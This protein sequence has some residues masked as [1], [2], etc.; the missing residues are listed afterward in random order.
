MQNKW[1]LGAS[2]YI[3]AN[4]TRKRILTP[5]FAI[6][7]PDCSS[8]WQWPHHLPCPPPTNAENV[9]FCHQLYFCGWKWLSALSKVSP[10]LSHASWKRLR[11]EAPDVGSQTSFTRSFVNNFGS[12]G[13]NKLRCFKRICLETP[14][15]LAVRLNRS[16]LLHHS[17]VCADKWGQR[18]WE[19]V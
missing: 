11:C 8:H 18:A 16:V 17:R 13:R 15:A 4:P 9:C 12:E 6:K 3:F 2:F 10:A 19:C 14:A 1:N 7:A 5:A